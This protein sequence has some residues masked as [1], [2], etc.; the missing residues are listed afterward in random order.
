MVGKDL[1]VRLGQRAI[2]C[3]HAPQEE[4]MV[5]LSISGVGN[6]S[7]ICNWK[8]KIP[9]AIPNAEKGSMLHQM[10]TPVVEGEEG[11]KLPGLLGF[12]SMERFRGILDMHKREL[13]VPGPGD[14]R[15]VLPPGSVK[16]P[17]EKAP[18]GHLV[19]VVDAY[20]QVRVS[21]GATA[22]RA[23]HL[24]AYR[25]EISLNQKERWIQP[26]A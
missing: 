9:I 7:Q 13:I 19:M 22:D 14:V 20:E 25:E 10:T 3:G 12:Q 15:I 21:K 11:R 1:A 23:L 2:K 6:G 4:K 5:P 8:L 26:A 24:A 16:I 17:L 18:S